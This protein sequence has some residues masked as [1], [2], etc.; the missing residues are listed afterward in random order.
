MTNS[1]TAGARPAQSTQQVEEEIIARASTG[2]PALPMLDVIFSRMP[3]GLNGTLKTRGAVLV[4]AEVEPVIYTTWSDAVEGLGPYSVC[5]IAEADPWDGNIVAAMDEDL[6]FATLETQMNGKPVP[7]TAPKRAPSMIERRIARRLLELVLEEVT[8][9]FGRMTEVRFKLDTVET[10]R[11]VASLHGTASPCAMIRFRMNVG[12]C[13]G[14]LS[15]LF[16]LT[17]LEP[18]QSVLSKMFLGE[19]LGGDG[20]W[21]EYIM[22]RI[23]GSRVS[24]YAQLQELHMD[25]GEL[26]EWEAGTTID[27][28]I[29]ADQEATIMCSG[30]P[31]LHGAIGRRKNDRIAVRI[32]REEENLGEEH[33][34]QQ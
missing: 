20:T 27:L 24:V 14:T 12:E 13:N 10:P 1:A 22:E 34:V 15:I 8:E 5:G 30:I 18:A 16:P 2:M 32:T 7:N 23:S 9:C 33:G 11:Q 21:R 29:G 28:G 6:F 3:T 26:L 25:L 19:K 4:E 17:T 31:V